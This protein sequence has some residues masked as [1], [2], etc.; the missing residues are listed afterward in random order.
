[1]GIKQNFQKKALQQLEL[2][3]SMP[4]QYRWRPQ[5][6]KRYNNLIKELKINKQ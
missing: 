3:K 6:E 5:D 2:K 1:M 4:N